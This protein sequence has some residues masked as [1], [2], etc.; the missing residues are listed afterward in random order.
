MSYL[1]DQTGKFKQ[2]KKKI[3]I[4]IQIQIHTNA[5]SIFIAY[6]FVHNY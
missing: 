1:L 3:K 6:A 2:V 4:Q 5:F